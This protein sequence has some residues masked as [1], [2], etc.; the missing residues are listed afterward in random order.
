MIVCGCPIVNR[1]WAIPTWMRYL[2]VQTVRPDQLV[3]VVSRSDDSTEEVLREHAALYQFPIH[4]VADDQIPH[5]RSDN[6]RFHTLAGLR[7]ELLATVR[8]T[9]PDA[10]FLSLDSDIMLRDPA[11]IER[12]ASMLE[13][14][15]DVASCA[16][17]FHPG[18]SM[19]EA[20]WDQDTCWAYN[21][22][23]WDPDSVPGSS[24][25]DWER[26][27]PK[28]IRWGDTVPID[29]PMGVW[30]AKPEVLAFCQ[31]RWHL[32]GEDLGFA[33]DLDQNRFRV[34]WDTAIRA[35]HI[36]QESHLVRSSD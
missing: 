32:S 4:V 33:Q 23:W 31:Y 34:T 1:A 30:L 7:N 20:Q 27:W 2:S 21:A 35:Q 36:W 25:R 6:K 9:W 29:I 10:R 11:T 18:A 22:G 17:F 3:F 12:L 8:N 24:T 28:D 16:T 5:D 19:P 26:P 13:D 15:A 14:D